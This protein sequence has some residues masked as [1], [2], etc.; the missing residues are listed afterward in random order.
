VAR[1]T[2]RRA[3]SELGPT[4]L[5]R[6]LIAKLDGAG[7][8]FMVVG[9]FASTA[10]GEPRTT[11]DLDVVI[12]PTRDAL[13]H[14]LAGLDPEQ[15]YVDADVARDAL[16]RRSMFNVIEMATA[17][18]V[19]FVIRKD[20]A[21]SIEELRRRATATIADVPTPTATAE[22]TILSKL[23]WAKVSASDRQ[24]ADVAGILRIRA[25]TLDIPYLEYWLDTLELRTEWSRA[26]ALLE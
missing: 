22:D 19:D 10:H 6:L 11:R 8:P 23:E 17:W 3:V 1:R 18:K 24:L 13:D 15:F 12:D 4:A 7:I 26:R 20:R 2:R 9:S 21:F 14:F 25:G 5:L 16:L